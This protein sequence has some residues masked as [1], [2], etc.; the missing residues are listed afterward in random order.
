M[1]FPEEYLD[2]NGYVLPG[3][4]ADG[5]PADNCIMYT[6]IAKL[7]GYDFPEWGN[8]VRSCYLKPGLVA[9]W[10][11]NNYD[12]AQW[13]DYLA[14]A[15]G[16]I[17]WGD[18][19]IARDILAYGATHFGFFNTD[20]KF[21]LSD[22]LFRNIP[23]WPLMIVAAFPKLKYLMAIPLY[24]IALSFKRPSLADSSAAQL[25]WL[26]LTGVYKLFPNWQIIQDKHSALVLADFFHTYY[27][28]GH[29]FQRLKK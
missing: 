2:R 8:M 9:R 12:Q 26:Y 1:K 28:E 21:K 15:V 6:T 7:L 16:C 14:I 20:G 5:K 22:F 3:T 17:L 18:R 13:D 11:G 24:G 27:A 23:V 19:S 25:Q 10:P 29:P 4:S